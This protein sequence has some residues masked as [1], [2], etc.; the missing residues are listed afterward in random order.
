VDSIWVMLL[1]T[2]ELLFKHLGEAM[3]FNARRLNQMR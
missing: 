3:D 2:L 1:D